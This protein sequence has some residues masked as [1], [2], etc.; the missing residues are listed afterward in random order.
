M[1]LSFEIVLLITINF[2]YSYIVIFMLNICLDKNKVREED[3]TFIGLCFGIIV[4]VINLISAEKYMFY[5]GLFSLLAYIWFINKIN[6][7]DICKI[8]SLFYIITFLFGVIKNYVYL[9][10]GINKLIFIENMCVVML[11]I[12]TSDLYVKL[13]MFCIKFYVKKFGKV[14]NFKIIYI[15]EFVITPFLISL[16]FNL[17][18]LILDIK[19][20]SCDKFLLFLFNINFVFIINFIL[21]NMYFNINIKEVHKMKYYKDLVANF[22]KYIREEKKAKHDFKQHILIMN[23]MVDSKEYE[24]LSCYIKNIFDRNEKF[25]YRFI[26]TGNLIIDAI[27]N[28]KYNKALS[29]N[30]EFLSNLFIPENLKINEHE[31]GVVLGNILDNAIEAAEK[32]EIRNKFVEVFIKYYTS[33]TLMVIVKN[34][35]DGKRDFTKMRTTK[36]HKKDHGFGLESVREIMHKNNGFFQIKYDE[37]VFEVKILFYDV[38]INKE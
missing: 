11:I 33:E 26:N 30:I 9:I 23:S 2:I 15:F 19:I 21:N 18:V 32:V 14:L 34:A 29:L 25:N 3:F 20:N 36:K 4:S 8:F 12:L 31:L 24:P 7:K 28:N 16:V 5:L 6:F 1:V 13:L 27:I 38:S 10:L 37:N 35:Y 22:N 17:V